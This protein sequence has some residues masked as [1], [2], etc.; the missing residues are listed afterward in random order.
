MTFEKAKELL[1]EEYESAIKLP[2]INDPVAY[3]LYKV[4]K[5]E[6][7]QRQNLSLRAMLK[8]NTKSKNG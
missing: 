8:S 7:E 1:D 2:Y 3:S 6:D 5:Q 4:W